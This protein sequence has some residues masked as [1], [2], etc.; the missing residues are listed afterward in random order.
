ML[1]PGQIWRHDRFYLDSDAGTWRAKFLLVL[2]VAGG[3]VVYRLLTSRALRSTDPRCSHADPYPS[4]Y[5]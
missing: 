5:L 1:F 3:D 2:A 4:F